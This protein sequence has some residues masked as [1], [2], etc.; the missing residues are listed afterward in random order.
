MFQVLS[1]PSSP[2]PTFPGQLLLLAWLAVNACS[3]LL[4]LFEKVEIVSR[5]LYN[6]HSNYIHFWTYLL[7]WLGSYR[8]FYGYY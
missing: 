3:F 5:L 2:T 8:V 4:K 1:V 6:M 7:L